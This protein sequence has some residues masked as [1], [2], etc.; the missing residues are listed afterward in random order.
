MVQGKTVS[1]MYFL[2][3]GVICLKENTNEKNEQAGL[4]AEK[5]SD[6]EN[7]CADMPWQINVPGMVVG[8]LEEANIGQ[9][10]L[11]MMRYTCFEQEQC[12]ARCPL[13]EILRYQYVSLLTR[14]KFCAW[15]P[16]K[17]SQELKLRQQRETLTVAH[18]MAQVYLSLSVT[19]FKA[20]SDVFTTCVSYI[21]REI[22]ELETEKLHAQAGTLTRS[23]SAKI[24]EELEAKARIA[25]LEAEALAARTQVAFGGSL[26]HLEALEAQI[27]REKAYAQTCRDELAEISEKLR[28]IDHEVSVHE[29]DLKLHEDTLSQLSRTS[30]LEERNTINDF[31]NQKCQRSFTAQ[32]ASDCRL[33]KI[34]Y[35]VWQEICR[36]ERL[37]FSFQTVFRQLVGVDGA[38]ID[39]YVMGNDAHSQT[40]TKVHDSRDTKPLRSARRA[41]ATEQF[42]A[43]HLAPFLANFDFLSHLTS[44]NLL[45]LVL[46]SKL[47]VFDPF[48]VISVQGQM[49]QSGLGA[50]VGYLILSGCLSKHTKPSCSMIHSEKWQKLQQLLQRVH[51]DIESNSNEDPVETSEMLELIRLFE[52]SPMAVLD[53]CFGTVEEYFEDQSIGNHRIMAFVNCFSHVVTLRVDLRM[54]HTSSGRRPLKGLGDE[55]LLDLRNL[56]QGLGAGSVIERF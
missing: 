52:S 25:G 27:E 10:C 35:A 55:V 8:K 36:M 29:A 32:V 4:L 7:G 3:S 51:K 45:K 48:T 40:L 13:Y 34:P 22:E 30:V 44:D 33:L 53:D 37:Y 38:C 15:Q 50:Q 11:S 56:H 18:E 14:H 47:R 24:L 26:G 39:G 31:E 2:L 19:C 46:R 17:A 41:K 23:L 12:F 16:Q 49:L 9:V 20:V 42:V 21:Q 28:T 6:G 1:A 54:P 5:T 43:A